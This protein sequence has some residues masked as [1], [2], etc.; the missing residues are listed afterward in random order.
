MFGGNL[1]RKAEPVLILMTHCLFKARKKVGLKTNGMV[2]TFRIMVR[3]KN[4]KHAS[5]NNGDTL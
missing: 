1:G 3:D 5:L 4:Y 2:Q